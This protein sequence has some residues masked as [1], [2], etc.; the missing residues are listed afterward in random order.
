M[1]RPEKLSAGSDLRDASRQQVVSVIRSAGQI[2][3]IDIAQETGVSPATVTAITAEL[4]QAG[5]VEEVSPDAP[6]LAPA[7][8][9]RGSR[10]GCAVRPMC[11]PA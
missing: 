10:S 3:R 9:A 6:P 1:A 4:I 8:G 2:A 11:S 5:L 7:A